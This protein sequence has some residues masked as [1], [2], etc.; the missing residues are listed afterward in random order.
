MLAQHAVAFVQAQ[1]GKLAEQKKSSHENSSVNMDNVRDEHVYFQDGI[2]F[3]N[4]V[5][6]VEVV[7]RSWGQAMKGEYASEWKDSDDKE[8]TKIQSFGSYRRVLRATV[9]RKRHVGHLLRCLRIKMSGERKTRWCYNGKEEDSNTIQEV[10]A[11][12]MRQQ[13]SRCVKPI[14]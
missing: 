11:T 4:T 14:S 6:G 12:V 1:S 10:K 9:D 2:E 8:H 7:P 5:N 13:A 3:A